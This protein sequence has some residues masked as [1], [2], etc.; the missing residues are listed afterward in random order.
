MKRETHLTKPEQFTLVYNEGTT[1]KDRYLVLKTRPNQ[2]DFSRYGISVSKRI[3]NAV[4]RNKAKRILREI[5]RLSL[6]SPGWDI[7][8]IVRGPAANSDYHQLSKSVADLLSRS[9]VTEE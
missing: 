2:L 9:H 7:I 4:V 6:L 8:L 1:Q 3:G 5:L